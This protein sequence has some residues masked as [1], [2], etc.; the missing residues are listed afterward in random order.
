MIPF[1][2][3]EDEDTIVLKYPNEYREVKFENET[4]VMFTYKDNEAFYSKK[5]NENAK[6]QREKLSD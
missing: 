5:E 4:Y 3:F 2:R 1:L 6:I